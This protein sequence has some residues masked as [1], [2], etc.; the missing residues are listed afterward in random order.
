MYRISRSP[1]AACRR[2]HSSV[3]SSSSR[4][5]GS[6]SQSQQ[7]G[8]PEQLYLEVCGMLFGSNDDQA[9]ATSEPDAA[10]D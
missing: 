5:S 6:F 7:A 10:D 8:Y 2:I 1:A 9:G 4:L 3:S